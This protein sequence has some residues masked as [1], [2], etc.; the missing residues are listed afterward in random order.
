MSNE[1]QIK[2]DAGK[3]PMHL[4]SKRLNEAYVRVR[5][6]GLKK[7]PEDSWKKVAPRRYLDAM[8]RHIMEML[9]NP[10]STDEESG[11]LHLEHV[12]CNAAFILELFPC[13]RWNEFLKAGSND[14]T[15]TDNQEE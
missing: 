9:D 3:L 7:Y 15:N 6:Y 13:S 12:I 1:Q 5:Q 10:Y 4:T 8:I 11:L 2:Q 14:Y